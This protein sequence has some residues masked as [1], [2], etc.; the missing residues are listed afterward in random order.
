MEHKDRRHFEFAGF[1]LGQGLCGVQ[2]LSLTQLAMGLLLLQK[3]V[4]AEMTTMLILTVHPDITWRSTT[5]PPA[6]RDGHRRVAV[7]PP[8][9]SGSVP[10]YRTLTRVR[11]L[12]ARVRHPAQIQTLHRVSFAACAPSSVST[13]SEVKRL[14]ILLQCLLEKESRSIRISKQDVN[15]M[16]VTTG[17]R[18]PIVPRKRNPIDSSQI[19]STPNHF[20]HELIPAVQAGGQFIGS[21]HDWRKGHAVPEV[22]H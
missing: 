9:R 4:L 7:L 13:P 14:E 16:P 21:Q 12:A 22:P 1:Q 6:F 5:W 17:H 15:S 20:L 10:R 2:M 18:Q 3:L 11:R 8:Q 19:H